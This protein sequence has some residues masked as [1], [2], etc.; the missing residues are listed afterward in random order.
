MAISGRILALIIFTMTLGAVQFW[1][2]ETQAQSSFFTSRGCSACHAAPVVA[3]CKGCHYHGASSLSGATNKTSYAPG[4]TVSVTI[5]SGSRSGW[6]R[7]ILYDQNNQQVAISNGNESGM[8]KSTTLPTV[9]SAPAP[10]VAG[11]YRWKA[12]WF[13]NINNTG[14]A[15]GEVTA[16]TNSFT[17]TAPVPTDTTAPVLTLSTLANNATTSNATLNV[18]G[19]VSD[20][21]GI[22]SLTV[23]GLTVT[24]TGGSFSTALTLT[25][26]ANSITTIATDNAGNKTTD[27][28]TINLDQAGPLLTV[29]SP[30]DNSKINKTFVD[31]SGTVGENSTVTVNGAAAAMNGLTFSSTVNLAA[32]PN[33]IDISATDLTGNTSTAKRSVTSDTIAPSLAVTEPAQDT[34]TSQSSI[35]IS[36]TIADTL[37]AVTVTVAVDGQTFTPAVANGL[38]SQ[39]IALNTAKTYAVTVTAAD[40]AGNQ[41]SVTRNIISSTNRMSSGDISGD[42]RVDLVDAQ[43][44][45]RI[46]VGLMAMDNLYLAQGDVSPFVGGA[47]Q[48]DGKIDISD[49]LI[50]LKSIVGLVTL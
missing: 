35:I 19:T 43:M 2:T 23:N 30:A 4:E 48:P 7:A 27:T 22:A 3:S 18:S 46:A 1:G 33:T 42:G 40:E 36:G 16:N 34:T 47:A 8:G 11:T 5:N 50:V 32:G 6:V 14:S 17:V 31:V 29:T 25:S 41:T 13:G 15:H 38:F 26:G 10:T 9:L 37:T 21:G 49:A 24:V 20:A 39:T 44:E 12:A 28:R 45:L